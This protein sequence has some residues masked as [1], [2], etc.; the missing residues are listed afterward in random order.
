MPRTKVEPIPNAAVL[1]RRL[2]LSGIENRIAVN[3]KDGSVL[4]HVPPGEFEMGDG[5]HSDCPKHQVRLSGY[6]IGVYAVTRAQYRG[7]LEAMRREQPDHPALE[8]G[9]FHIDVPSFNS[10]DQAADM[11]SWDEADAYAKWAGCELA[12]EAQWER[13]ARGPLGLKYPWGD[14]WDATRCCHEIGV[15]REWHEQP[16]PVHGYPRGVSGYGSYNQ[17][18]NVY[19]LCRDRYGS[20]YYTA[21]PAID[22]EGPTEGCSERVHRGGCWFC[23]N[24]PD[25]SCTRRRS[26]TP[27][28]SLSGWG[29]RLV[30]TTSRLLSS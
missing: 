7:F 29:F 4:V 5:Q 18:G 23:G 26:I 10:P 13:A 14:D 9:F 2:L 21:S 24:A 15:H 30:K 27:G 17:N 19:E 28:A 25:L 16:A 12:T 1:T 8:H 20:D 11:V 6:W 22:P 3:A